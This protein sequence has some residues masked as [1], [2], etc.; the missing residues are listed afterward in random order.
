MKLL[1]IPIMII[2]TP[3]Y[4]PP[5]FSGRRPSAS[6]HLC[7]GGVGVVPLTH[8]CTNISAV[9]SVMPSLSAGSAPV[10]T[11][12]RASSGGVTV[13][14]MTVTPSSLN[15]RFLSGYRFDQHYTMNLI[16]VSL[17]WPRS[18]ACKRVQD[19]MHSPLE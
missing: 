19:Q 5:N 11:A 12:S 13:R 1:P 16:S 8:L 2:F 17:S 14:V 10:N 3:T 15:F 6:F 18:G 4:L 7:E 9:I